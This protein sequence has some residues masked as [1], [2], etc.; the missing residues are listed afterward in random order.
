M[1]LAPPG[2]GTPSCFG[3]SEELRSFSWERTAQ[4]CPFRTPFTRTCA[5]AGPLSQAESHETCAQGDHESHSRAAATRRGGKRSLE[6]D[7]PNLRQGASQRILLRDPT[8]RRTA[9]RAWIR[10]SSGS[11]RCRSGLGKH[12]AGEIR[13]A[14]REG[15]HDVCEGFLRRRQCRVR[16]RIGAC[17]R[18]D[19]KV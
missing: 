16:R 11:C 2:D 13:R 14:T 10:G 17:V 19:F 9:C 3:P 5:R 6:P 18:T 8:S 1:F 12:H 7:R 4:R 15:N